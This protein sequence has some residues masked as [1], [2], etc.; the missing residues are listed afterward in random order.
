MKTKYVD[1]SIQ[2][3]HEVCSHIPGVG[4]IWLTLIVKKEIHDSYIIHQV[5]IIL[6]L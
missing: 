4:V 6:T 5:Y 1:K 2:T 3:F